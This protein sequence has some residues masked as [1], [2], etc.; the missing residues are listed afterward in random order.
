MHFILSDEESIFDQQ[1][2]NTNNK[3]NNRQG[4]GKNN[5][6]NNRKNFNLKEKKETKNSKKGSKRD[7]NERDANKK[8][9]HYNNFQKK[10]ITIFIYFAASI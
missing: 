4:R 3:E 8:K 7:I 2:L 9:D 6:K 5:N 1:P 10:T